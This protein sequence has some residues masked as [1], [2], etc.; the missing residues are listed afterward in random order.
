M[1]RDNGETVM[2]AFAVVAGG[3]L[4]AIGTTRIVVVMQAG[5]PSAKV[6]QVIARL[7]PSAVR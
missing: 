6:G 1:V 4:V 7:N 5:N 2:V 3:W